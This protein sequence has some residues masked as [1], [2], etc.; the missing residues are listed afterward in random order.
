MST[1]NVEVEL[2]L[3]DDVTIRAEIQP[4]ILHHIGQRL[5][6]ADAFVA[7][8]GRFFAVY[9]AARAKRERSF[10]RPGERSGIGSGPIAARR[11]TLRKRQ[12]A[13]ASRLT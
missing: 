6:D 13:S 10:R 1:A 7:A 3:P 8:R 11:W 5:L 4:P 12:A 2:D 9:R